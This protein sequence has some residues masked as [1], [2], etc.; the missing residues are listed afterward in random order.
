MSRD[1]KKKVKP[2]NWW[3]GWVRYIYTDYNGSER[4]SITTTK[5]DFSTAGQAQRAADSLAGAMIRPLPVGSWERKHHSK[6][7]KWHT[8]RRF[9]IVETGASRVD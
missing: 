6:N 2:L 5:Y 7:D 8:K 4:E 9:K 1:T 3:Y